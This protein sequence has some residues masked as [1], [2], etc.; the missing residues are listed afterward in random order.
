M[1]YLSLLD[2]SSKFWEWNDNYKFMFETWKGLV[3]W[4]CGSDL[5]L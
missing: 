2:L 3:L 1:L 4:L 5:D